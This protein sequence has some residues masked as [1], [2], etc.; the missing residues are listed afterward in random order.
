MRVNRIGSKPKAVYIK[1]IKVG[2]VYTHHLVNENRPVFMK[3]EE[4]KHPDEDTLLHCV[5]LSSDGDS[6]KVVGEMY[7]TYSH[8]E[9]YLLDTTLNVS[10]RI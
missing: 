3:T 2:E 8:I 9:C 1:D 5:C 6:F 4:V 7:F 10:D